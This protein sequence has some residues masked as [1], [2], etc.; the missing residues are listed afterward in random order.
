MI[1]LFKLMSS[2]IAN[3]LRGL[4]IILKEERSLWFHIPVALLVIVFGIVLKV[5]FID[6]SL[7]IIA[8]SLVVGCEIINT[9]IEYIV[10]IISF[11]YNVKAKKIKDVSAAAVLFSV[12]AGIIIVLLVFIPY[13]T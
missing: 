7:I 10:D 1:R 3:A 13:L 4:W 12:V 5:T 9:A 11:E 6:W 2:K 8:I